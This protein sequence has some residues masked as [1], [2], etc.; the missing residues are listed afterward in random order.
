MNEPLIQPTP[1]RHRAIGVSCAILITVLAHADWDPS[2]G[3]KWVQLPD[4]TI[5]GMD[6]KDFK[7]GTLPLSSRTLA[8]DWHCTVTEAITNI[9]I[10]GSWYHDE[11]PQDYPQSVAFVLAIHAD[12]PA[13]PPTV[14]FSKPGAVLWSRTFPPGT[15]TA[16]QYAMMT[17]GYE[18]WFEPGTNPYFEA[19]GDLFCWQYNFTIKDNPFTQTGSP[20][21]PVVYWLEVQAVYPTDVSL[22]RF[23][24]KTSTQHWN[25]SAVYATG[26]APNSSGNWDML[27]YPDAHPLKGQ[28]IDL[29]FV[30]NGAPRRLLH[31]R[32]FR[33]SLLPPPNGLYLPPETQ[34]VAFANGLLL[35]NPAHRLFTASVPPPPT[36]GDSLT[37]TFGSQVEMEVSMDGG[38]TWLP[39]VSGGFTQVHIVN[40]GPEG[41]D[42][43]YGTEMLALNIGGGTLPAGVMIR[44]SPTKASTGQTRIE[45]I[46]GG[47]MIDSFFDIFTEVSTDG[48]IT[49]HPS[50]T[51][52]TM[53][54]TV[55]PELIPAVPA[56]RPVEPM[57][58][59]QHVSTEMSWEEYANGIVIQG[60]QNRRFTQ[61]ADPPV[62]GGS[63]THTFDSQLDFQLS[64]DGGAHFTS[65]HTPS[66]L[67]IET[68]HVREFQGR[69]TYETEVTQYDV[70]GGDL[71]LGVMIRESPTR[72]SKGGTSSLAGGGGGG[73]GGGAA[74]S[75]FFDIFTEV[76]TDGGGSWASATNGPAH[77][78]LQ[79]IAPANTYGSNLF[80]Q[81]SGQYVCRKLWMAY[82][83][84]GIVITNFVNRAF[85]QGITPPAPG[86][87]VS[88]SF[89]SQA[90]MDISY[91]GG[92]TYS[93]VNAPGLNTAQITCRLGGDGVTE[94]YDTEMTQLDIS[95]G[96]L[97]SNIL[98]RES[99]TK[100]S[101]GRTT[102]SANSTDN[103][104]D[105]FFDIYI[106]VSTDGGASWLQ[107]LAGPGT[108]ILNPLP[109]GPTFDF[110]DAPD[111]TYPTL[112]AS[113]GARHVIV[114]Q[115]PFLGPV[116]D[117]P[118]AEADGQPNPTATGDDLA[119]AT[120]DDEDG[121]TFPLLQSGMPTTISVIVGQA[122][123]V[124]GWIDWNG[125]GIWQTPAERV[126]SSN[127]LA[128][129]HA[130]PV[131]PPTG[132]FLGQTFARFRIH[133]GTS[134]LPPTGPASDGEV[135]DY[136]VQIA[137]APVISDPQAKWWQ[138]PDLT[139]NG[140]DVCATYPLLL[141]DDFPCTNRTA[142]TNIVVW[143]SWRKDILPSEGPGAPTFFLSI[144]SDIPAVTGG[145]Q[146]SMP[147]TA[148]WWRPCPPSTYSV[149]IER[150]S[151]HEGWYSPQQEEYLPWTEP[152]DTV[153]YRYTF[154][155]P[156]VDAFVQTGTVINPIVYWLDVQAMPVGTEPAQFGW[157]TSISHWND[158]A[159]WTLGGEPYNGSWYR[160]VYP[161]LHPLYN[162]AKFDMAFALYGVPVEPPQELDFGDAPDPTYPTL[163][164][165]DGARHALSTLI[166]GASIDAEA[167]GQPTPGAN[168][169]DLANLADEDGV[170]L[171][172]V[173]FTPGTSGSVNVTSSGSG[174]LDAWIDFNQDGDWSDSGEQIATSQTVG[175]GPNTIT[176]AVPS[177]ALSGRTCARFRLSSAG[178]LTYTGAAADGEVEDYIVSIGDPLLDFGDAPDS[179]AALGYPTYLAN[180]GARHFLRGTLFMGT[181]PDSE[182]DG[183]PNASATGDD[184]AG[185]DD[186]DGVVFIT[187]FYRGETAKMRVTVS[188]AGKLDAWIDLN[189]DADWNDSGEQM[190]ASLAVT[191]GVNIVSFF[192]P[193]TAVKAA[194]CLR[195]R[196]STAGGL[197]PTGL[198]NDGEVE[199]Y[200]VTIEDRFPPII[201]PK[202]FQP[203]DLRFG[204][205]IQS[206]GFEQ[207]HG[208]YLVAD[209][210]WC[211]GRPIDAIRWWGSYLA[212]GGVS[213]APGI[214]VGGLRPW[215]FR[216]HWY[217][218]VPATNSALGYSTPGAELLSRD[219]PLLSFTQ[220][221]N[222]YGMVKE[223]YAG[224]VDLSFLG[225]L[226]LGQ[227]EHKF[228]YDLYLEDSWNEKAGNIYWLGI[229]ALY[230]GEPMAF[231]W[232]WSTTPYLRNWNDDAVVRTNN[233]T[234]APV[235]GEMTYLPNVPPYDRLHLHPYLGRSVNMAFQLFS[236]VTPRRAYIWR[237]P[238]D[239]I[240][241]TDLASWQCKEG[242][243]P[244]GF[245]PTLR[246]DDWYS[247]GRRVSNV[248]WWGSFINW[249]HTT[250]EPVLP[251]TPGEIN[252]PL[253]F[254]LSLH[255]DGLGGKPGTVITNLFVPFEYCHQTYYCCVTQYWWKVFEHE[256]QYYVDLLDP[257]I[258]GVP[259]NVTPNER[260]WLDIQAIFAQGFDPNQGQMG[261][262]GWGWK[263]TPE[264][265]HNGSVVATNNSMPFAWYTGLYPAGHPFA[266]SP[267]DLAF[268]LTTDK[269]GT[270]RWHAAPEIIGIVIPTDTSNTVLVASVGDVLAGEQQL[271][272]ETALT[273]A[274]FSTTVD[275]L[276]VPFPPPATNWFTTVVTTNLWEFY[277]IYQV[278][279]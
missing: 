159:T 257:R 7:W 273:N 57:P 29:S 96:G 184:I 25:D 100:A 195:F 230:G 139:T 170:S 99:P 165:N 61:W 258:S 212:Y 218:D 8:D 63:L 51:P 173:P 12:I 103:D 185:V 88:H 110:G 231:Q 56:P 98:L 242:V 28:A 213:N 266:G 113:N 132:A 47:Y 161:P 59:G 137:P 38:V 169:D 249:E 4:L 24:W 142:I 18:G 238:P 58:N 233:P 201:G 102:V 3:A 252:S 117:Q 204:I 199:D 21:S 32:F 210:W 14:P 121:V 92:L 43:L 260:Y 123:W 11:W 5:Q 70:A 186:E 243:M 156:L 182:A 197:A 82:F 107:T 118:D 183:Q 189:A 126:V 112:L 240:N 236:R 42:I 52:M 181:A 54:L 269:V 229:E 145:P 216:L 81:L 209:D 200:A 109:L 95:G 45:T 217:A 268:E 193:G 192:V 10:W 239:M 78:E 17:Q 130:I 163:L 152:G 86:T 275:N 250:G 226:Y 124:D 77:E 105:S 84:N 79:R 191:A 271:R 75:S 246:A 143:G 255:A 263:T 69:T 91:D 85:T 35:R 228:R 106:E 178:G 147:G 237:Q 144:H 215:G 174:C 90:E 167:D 164:A 179:Y 97:L 62:I 83:A 205:D 140:L 265:T 190:A 46:P 13:A 162:R 277:R 89:G 244:P 66:T 71:P 138:S 128:G 129:A 235:W 247:E 148:L 115:G 232:G 267:A 155:I 64:T 27:L 219:V 176:F 245:V 177:G 279:P 198:A 33:Q 50:S 53:A 55:D 73:A 141:A 49:W 60:L 104:C 264:I 254:K 114:S 39:Y 214:P 160:L 154:Q 40:N 65:V 6:V 241:G 116:G 262:Y 125:D 208:P 16:R 206:W 253:G 196:L 22:T 194:T 68:R 108:V 15:F 30:I 72:A 74:I 136:P 172:A 227:L 94:Y 34:T 111:P 270:N 119:G 188:A 135:E 222:S 134:A 2:D 272:M 9:H 41:G 150:D 221:L 274:T 26:F 224:T 149:T 101:L 19:N 31:K 23:G 168:G 153:C 166:L 223:V 276:T 1:L 146:Y 211:D 20:Q 93:H 48:G 261:H 207:S 80:P 151:L 37:H 248:H 203:P 87:T 187:P 158:D 171:P 220:P 131:T 120:P 122:G 251:P 76:S 175:V 67:T 256:Y 225:P 234:G 133:T 202:W 180:N 127:L 44:E 157:K 36:P 278:N 259:W